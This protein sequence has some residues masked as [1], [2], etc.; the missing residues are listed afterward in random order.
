MN[1]NSWI[2]RLLIAFGLIL[3]TFSGAI[4]IVPQTQ[5]AII[6]QFG[7]L[8][9]VVKEPG[10]KFKIP[11]I[12]EV[13]LFEKRVLEFDLPAVPI[14][15][16]DQKRMLVDT[17]TRYRIFDPVLFFQTIK[18]ASELGAAMRLEALVSSTVRNVLGKIPLRSLLTKKRSSI[19]EQI[20]AEVERLT[21]PLG[22]EIVD[23]RIIRTELPNENR[24][25]VFARMNSDL[26][27]I[28]MENR[29]KGAEKAQEIRAI[30]ER[31]RT[32]ILAEAQ[33]QASQI[34]GAGESQALNIMATAL[35]SDPEFYNFYKSLE[36][37]Q[38][39][40]DEETPLIFSSDH[41]FFKY[42]SQPTGQHR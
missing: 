13:M 3:I 15:A 20:N 30:A 11:L 42:F 5:Q 8:V 28:A 41:T 33:K 1:L 10:L 2:H 16:G 25:A 17:Y 12:Q 36:I 14:T 4:F 21:R 39:S 34:R 23:V 40:I 38:E 19:M 26:Q 18:P 9:R 29:A 37:Y 7:E 27:R 22:M 24:A 31:D 32:V 6:L 35:K